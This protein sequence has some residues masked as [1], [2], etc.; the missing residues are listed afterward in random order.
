M[1][2][3]LEGQIVLTVTDNNGILFTVYETGEILFP[4]ANEE[5]L[6]KILQDQSLR[7]SEI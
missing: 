4:L 5:A 1:G 3:E 7:S 2:K 6:K